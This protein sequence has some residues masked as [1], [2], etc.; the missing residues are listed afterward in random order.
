SRVIFD[1]SLAIDSGPQGG[2]CPG[3]GATGTTPPVH[4]APVVPPTP[5]VSFRHHPPHRTSDRTPTFRFASSVPGSNFKRST[6]RRPLRPCEPP[7][8]LP[9]LG[10]GHHTFE[11][12]AVAAGGRSQ[13]LSY[14]FVVRR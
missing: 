10:F 2:P 11:V 3:S 7:F 8:P 13:P 5:T 6:A 4:P 14:A 1:L 9:R 12:V